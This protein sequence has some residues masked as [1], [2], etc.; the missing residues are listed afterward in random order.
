MT[1]YRYRLIDPALRKLGN[2]VPGP[3]TFQVLPST[4]RVLVDA[5]DTSK[6][7]LDES[8]R[9]YGYVEDTSLPVDPI[10]TVTLIPLT[11]AVPAAFAPLGG[12]VA[13]PSSFVSNPAQ[14]L[15]RVVGAYNADGDI[16]VRLTED[17]AAIG[18]GTLPAVGGD[19]SFAFDCPVAAKPARSIFVFE[20]QLAGA[21]AA[22][23][24]Y[25]SAGVLLLPAP[26]VP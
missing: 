7:D 4:L 2:E 1:V 5:P 26:V 21:L 25:V 20:A 6:P 14:L 10:A 3:L 8:M 11:A 15:I 17:G 16:Q 22:T 18:G 13:W 9:R 12:T 24:S 23:V 19:T